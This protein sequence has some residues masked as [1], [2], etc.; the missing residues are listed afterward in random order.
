MSQSFLDESYDDYPRIEAAFQAAL[1]ESLH[2][3]GREM[4]YEMVASLRLSR[5]ASVL[6][7]GCGEGQHSLRLARDFG[8]AV[9]AVDPVLRHIEIGNEALQTAATA[10]PELRNLVRFD[11]GAAEALPVPDA[12]VDLIW[13]KDVLVHVEALDRALAECRRVLRSRGFMLIYHSV[14]WTD[15]LKPGEA[16]LISSPPG[17]FQT[18][19]Q[20][21]EAS[22]AAAGFSVTECI[23][24]ASEW[25]E[26]EEEE[27]G[28]GGRRLIHTARLLRAPDRY[29]TQFGQAAY[30][31]ML[32]DCL[33]HIYRM[34]GKMSP[35]VYLLTIAGESG[36]S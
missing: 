26:R 31:I 33:W 18:D 23:E 21:V 8:F 25:G 35:R 32:G 29:I 34:I 2:P 13:C 24:L 15:R 14:F 19:P 12:S 30:D 7:L 3:R 27:T 1:D 17:I 20:R 4:L 36:P 6:D 10:N 5:G 22:F 9:H 11:V 16:E 28:A